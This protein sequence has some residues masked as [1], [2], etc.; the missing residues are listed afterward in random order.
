MRASR[1][2]AGGAAPMTRATRIGVL[3]VQ[4]A[5]AEHLADPGPHRF[6]RG[7]SPHA[8]RPRRSRRPH[9]A[10]WSTPPS[11]SSSNAGASQADPRSGRRRGAHL[12]H[13][14]RHRT[15]PGSRRIGG[16]R[17][18]R[19]AAARRRRHVATPSAASSTPSRAGRPMSPSSATRPST[20]SSSAPPSSSARGLDVDVL[21]ALPDDGRIVAVRRAAT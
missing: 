14:R 19:P 21:A 18:A 1:P 7:R 9:P 3:A 8:G 10:R 11:A 6:D 15:P 5:F 20:P 13:L 16:R 17:R 2:D 4:G 12:R